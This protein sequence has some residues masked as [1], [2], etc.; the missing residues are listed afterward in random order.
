MK[1]RTPTQILNVCAL[2]AAISCSLGI[3]IAKVPPSELRNYMLL[4]GAMLWFLFLATYPIAVL[5]YG[6]VPSTQGLPPGSHRSTSPA[7]FWIGLIA[8]TTLWV[9]LVAFIYLYSYMAWHPVA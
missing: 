9:G 4:L 6:A 8:T 2:I 1:S 5:Q 7:K 3:V